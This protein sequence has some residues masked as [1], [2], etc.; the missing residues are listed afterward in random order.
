M[1]NSLPAPAYRGDEVEAGGLEWVQK[2]RG[3]RGRERC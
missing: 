1:V 3:D 2:G